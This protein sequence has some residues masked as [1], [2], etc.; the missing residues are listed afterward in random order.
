MTRVLAGVIILGLL[1][2]C[3]RAA[4]RAEDG[5]VPLQV[6]EHTIRVEVAATP[7]TRE[8]GLMFRESL[9]PNTGMLF[10][11]PE[12]RRLSF[13]MKNTYIPL[14]IAFLDDDGIILNI[15]PM[16]PRDETSRTLSRGPARYALEMQQ[17]WF[18]EHGVKAG[19]RVPLEPI[20]SVTVE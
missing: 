2:V 7:D 3:N 6:G 15:E 20:Q 1:G 13:W 9:P 17:G 18:E 12:T 4:T 14:S 8:K 11:F 10:I 19:D 5:K 16:A